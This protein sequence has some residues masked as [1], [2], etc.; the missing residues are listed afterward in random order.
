VFPPLLAG[1]RRRYGRAGP[2]A[3]TGT[4]APWKRAGLAGCRPGGRHGP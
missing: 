3:A 1:G 4:I 2:A